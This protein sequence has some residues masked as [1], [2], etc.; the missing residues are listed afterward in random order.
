MILA[1]AVKYSFFKEYLCDSLLLVKHVEHRHLFILLRSEVFY[2][3]H[4]F[5]LILGTNH[6]IWLLD[7]T[8]SDIY[9]R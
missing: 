6:D 1:I 5:F 8:L 2:V 9:N 7:V 4:G 3:R